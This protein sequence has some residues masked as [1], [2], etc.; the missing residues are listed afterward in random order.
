M[1]TVNVRLFACPDIVVYVIGVGKSN[2]RVADGNGRKKRLP[3][4]ASHRES[5][6]SMNV[7]SSGSPLE[8]SPEYESETGMTIVG[9]E[10]TCT[11]FKH[12]YLRIKTVIPTINNKGPC[13]REKLFFLIP[14]G[15]SPCE[16]GIII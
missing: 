10:K 12:Y 2:E 1:I 3:R 13:G 4:V 16:C 11:R 9:R 15:Y 7:E 6:G 14:W 5:G 8:F